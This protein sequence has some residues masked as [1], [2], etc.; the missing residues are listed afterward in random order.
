MCSYIRTYVRTYVRMCI[1]A[2][3]RCVYVSTEVY[4]CT[5][6]RMH[7]IRVEECIGQWAEQKTP[8]SFLL[9]RTQFPRKRAVMRAIQEQFTHALTSKYI[10]MYIQSAVDKYS[11]LYVHRYK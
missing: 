10:R 8:G 5:Y 11:S 7:K 4:V 2:H 9:Q 1:P 3:V 6:V